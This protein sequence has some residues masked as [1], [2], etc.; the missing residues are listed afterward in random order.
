MEASRSDRVCR[1]FLNGC[2]RLGPRCNYRH[3]WSVS[4]QICRYFQKGGCWYGDRCRYLH[5]PQPQVGETVSSRRGSVPAVSSSHVAYPP[6]DR[7]GSEPALL[8]AGAMSRQECG[9][10][11]ASS[12]NSQNEVGHPAENNQEQQTLVRDFHPSASQDFLGQKPEVAQAFVV[13]TEQE[14]SGE[15]TT[16]GGAAAS[17]AQGNSENISN[18]TCGICM[19][20]VY[21]KSHPRNNVF[22]ILPNCNHAFC[23]QC[24]STWR[25]VRDYGPDVIK[26]CPVCRMKSAFYVPSKN[27]VEGQAKERL[28]TDF[29]EKCR[30]KTCRY[31]IRSGYC[32][33]KTDCLYMHDKHARRIPQRFF[34][35]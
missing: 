11:V 20:N 16:A 18:V 9:R 33:F 6:A 24:I 22:G 1:L 21:E 35:R 29:K 34:L 10:A 28:I 17:S 25:K 23:I 14:A 12:S 13:R 31:H 32:P 8:Q 26:S 3:E 27:W 15:V 7:R 30:K 19:D 4:A 5:V 2:C